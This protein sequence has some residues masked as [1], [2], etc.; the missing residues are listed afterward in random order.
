M[1]FTSKEK[2]HV[3]GVFL[4]LSKSFDSLDHKILLDKLMFIGGLPLKLLT[5]YVSDRQPAV[6]CNNTFS[7]F[8]TIR[9]G[10]LQGSVLDPT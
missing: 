6:Y 8:G 9:P 3:A 7:S 1:Q 5:S 2:Y 4:G 10:V